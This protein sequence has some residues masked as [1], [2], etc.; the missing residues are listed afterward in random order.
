MM[1]CPRMGYGA[2]QSPPSGRAWKPRAP[3]SSGQVGQGH[4]RAT[5]HPISVLGSCPPPLPPPLPWGMPCL[6]REPGPAFRWVQLGIDV[7]QKPVEHATTQAPLQLQAF[8]AVGLLSLGEEKGTGSKMEPACLI[9]EFTWCWWG[10]QRWL[11]RSGRTG[12]E[13]GAKTT[14]P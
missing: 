13:G 10:R 5:E 9:P 11:G 3:L 12:T 7:G 8:C 14:V 4:G 2:T 1:K 6:S